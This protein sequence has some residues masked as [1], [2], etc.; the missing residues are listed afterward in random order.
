MKRSVPCIAGQIW[1]IKGDYAITNAETKYMLVIREP[2]EVFSTI[3]GIISDGRAKKDGSFIVTIDEDTDLRF[4]LDMITTIGSDQ[5]RPDGYV[6]AVDRRDMKGLR[7]KILWLMDT[8]KADISGDT[9]TYTVPVE[10]HRAYMRRGAS[11]KSTPPA[12][13]PIPQTQPVSTTPQSTTFKIAEPTMPQQPK[14]TT[15][16]ITSTAAEIIMPVDLGKM[17]TVTIQK[18]QTHVAAEPQKEEKKLTRATVVFPE[19]LF[20][21]TLVFD[22]KDYQKYDVSPTAAKPYKCPAKRTMDAIPADKMASEKERFTVSADTVLAAIRAYRRLTPFDA[23]V[24]V[25]YGNVGANAKYFTEILGLTR[26]EW[27]VLI[28]ICRT[29]RELTVDEYNAAVKRWTK[30]AMPEW[31]KAYPDIYDNGT[32]RELYPNVVTNEAEPVPA[33]A[34]RLLAKNNAVGGAN[35]NAK[36][37]DDVSGIPSGIVREMSGYFADSKLN[38]LP[39]KFYEYF[40]MLPKWN[41]KKLWRSNKSQFETIYAAAYNRIKAEVEKAEAEKEA[42]A[43]PIIETAETGEEGDNAPETAATDIEANTSE[44]DTE[45]EAEAEAVEEGTE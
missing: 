8:D 12:E 2:S 18:P 38:L 7:S 28:W 27:Q 24:I 44:E 36:I 6:T 22:V 11:V 35:S 3:T 16:T 41:V 37:P 43:A 13:K 25:P 15:T 19:S 26:P 29:L 1:A 5:I 42:N 34:E 21:D 14:T 39:K 32:F 23:A 9:V 40:L 45:I 31:A 33:N 20:P 17:T 4:P 10:M 30:T